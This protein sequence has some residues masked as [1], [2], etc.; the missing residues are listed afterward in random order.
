VTLPFLEKF[1][2]LIDAAAALAG[3]DENEDSKANIGK[4]T[5]IRITFKNIGVNTDF[6]LISGEI[7]ASYDPKWGSMIDGDKA[8]NDLLGDTGTV[9]PIDVQFE[10][11]SVVK[12]ADGTLTITGTNGVVV[13]QPKTDNDVIITDR[14]GKQYAVSPSAPV[15]T[16]ESTGKAAPGGVP[17]PQNT[18]GM[19]SGGAIKQ[20]S[21]P[22][23]SITFAAGT[24]F[25]SLDENP[26][27]DPKLKDNSKLNSTYDVI[28]KK[29]GTNYYVH[30]KAVSDAPKSEDYITA[31]ATFSNGK[32]TADIVFKTENGTEIKPVWSG[33]VA[34]LT[35][36][37][38]LDFAKES[39]LATVKPPVQKDSVKVTAKYD[40]AGA[41]NMWHVTGKKVNV[42]LVSIN[43]APIPSDAATKLNEIYNKAGVQF[44]VNTK[45]ITITNDWGTSIE[46]GDSDLLDTYTDEQQSITQALI[47][48]LGS[49][50][51]TN[52]YYM[53]FTLE[54]ASNGYAGFM[55]LKKQFGF[56]FDGTNRTLAHELGHGIFGLRH[57]FTEYNT[58]ERSTNLLMDY[59]SGTELSHND[60]EIMHAPGLQLY[61]FT[62]GS[63]AGALAG[64][65]GLTP[66]FKFISAAE[67]NIVSTK[68]GLVAEGHLSGFLDSNNIKYIWN[69]DQKAYTINGEKTGS[70]YTLTTKNTIDSEATVW[71]IYNYSEDCTQVK[72]IHTKFKEIATIITLSDKVKAQQNLEDYIKLINPIPKNTTTKNIV[73]SGLLGCGN[74]NI[75]NNSAFYNV[76]KNS[77]NINLNELRIV[78]NLISKFGDEFYTT[79]FKST[80]NQPITNENLSILKISLT[81]QIELEES[82]F[83]KASF[84]NFKKIIAFLEKCKNDYALQTE[85]YIPRCLWDNNLNIPYIQ[86]PA[87]TAGVA[88]GL[89]ETVVGVYD[90]TAFATCFD[91]LQYRAWTIDCI[92]TRTKTYSVIKIAYETFTNYDHF[93]NATAGLWTGIKEYTIETASTSNQ[94]RYNQGKIIFNVASLFIGVGEANAIL[95]GE[96]TLITV[97]KESVAAYKQLP[98]SLAKLITKTGSKLKT[99]VIKGVSGLSLMYQLNTAEIKLGTIINQGGKAVVKI[100]VPMTKGTVLET[101]EECLYLNADNVVS[102]GT[103]EVV[104]DGGK[105][106]LG[107]NNAGDF[108]NTVKYVD[109][110]NVTSTGKIAEIIGE[111]GDVL[112]T[113]YKQKK[114]STSTLLEYSYK[115]KTP[116]GNLKTFN[117]LE[118][119]ITDDFIEFE[120]NIP[121]ELK[122]QGLGSTVLDDAIKY[123]DIKNPNYKGIRGRWEG[124][125]PQ[126]IDGMSDNFKTFKD[127]KL[128][129]KSDVAAAFETWTG[130]QAQKQG[131]IKA[132]VVTDSDNLVLIEFTK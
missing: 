54:K 114:Y 120:F 37:R 78:S 77:E 48:K 51:N 71:L 105:V 23:V 64:G 92:E 26:N 32:T 24:G 59:G 21:S 97:L 69:N 30:Y 11:K 2:K 6:K 12:N 7:V 50:Y 85:G 102:K 8:V 27:Q 61:Q 111:N 10:I 126:Y 132:K 4:Y 9:I 96:K 115:Y 83:G 65:Y 80:E 89:I 107:V 66:D 104:E 29:D 28:P 70:K 79:Y 82:L 75:N 76:Y 93:S 53:L 101:I 73:Y 100:E 22:D 81:K 122:G 129:N 130:K 110:Y 19:G 108:K 46:T 84:E 3:S 117:K 87:L 41:L 58:T 56:V 42:T 121:D 119:E 33:N 47:T 25:Y 16:I 39:I 44:D 99:K 60:W 125:D 127:A 35:L 40:I 1:R 14:N 131:F 55:P 106:G 13:Q 62:Q 90:I 74:T 31:K 34:T 5:R 49:E 103:I 113:L 67:S 20:I 63:S 38:T 57:P 15:G 124:A 52:T 86:D 118:A 95:K 116:S 109:N 94:A 17:T 123:Y 112:G 128:V 36:K 68:A 43:K 72:Y 18:N 98:K 45:E 91:F 88:D